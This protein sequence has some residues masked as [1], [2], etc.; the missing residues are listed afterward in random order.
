MGPPRSL[1]LFLF[2]FLFFNH[3]QG[4]LKVCHVIRY[5]GTDGGILL[6]WKM[7]RVTTIRTRGVLEVR[8]VSQYVPEMHSGGTCVTLCVRGVLASVSYYTWGNVRK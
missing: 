3:V 2:L 7:C 8:S 1:F 5:I 4:N 6:Y